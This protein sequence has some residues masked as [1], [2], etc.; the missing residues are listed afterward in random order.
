MDQ[1]AWHKKIR[2]KAAGICPLALRQSSMTSMT[3]VSIISG[4]HFRGSLA[5]RGKRQMEIGK[6]SERRS[7]SVHMLT[8]YLLH[9]TGI[10]VE[11]D[12]R[13]IFTSTVLTLLFQGNH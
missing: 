4:T 9:S 1:K 7:E 6:H 12:G 5:E 2:L 3:H 8:V 13:L 10:L 11:D